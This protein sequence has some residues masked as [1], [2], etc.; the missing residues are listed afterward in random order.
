MPT[1]WHAA[2]TGNH[3]GLIIDEAGNNIAVAYDAKDATL[4]AA[5][6]ELL[7]ALKA[8]ADAVARY[9][10][11]NTADDIDSAEAGILEDAKAA[12]AAIAKATE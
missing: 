8:L 10:G 2:K 11:A 9:E 6:P 12:R 1:T 3:Q 4:I 5:A 7:E